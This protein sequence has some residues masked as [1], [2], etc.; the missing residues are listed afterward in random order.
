MKTYLDMVSK[1][2]KAMSRM[3]SLLKKKP[4]MGRRT[5]NYT[6]SLKWQNTDKF[7]YEDIE[8]ALANDSVTNLI[9]LY[10]W[11]DIVLTGPK[12]FRPTQ[13]QF[14]VLEHMR[15]SLPLEDY[16]QPFETVIIE[17]PNDYMQTKI[18]HLPQ[19][20]TTRG[21]EVL[22]ENHQPTMLMLRLDKPNNLLLTQTIFDSGFSIKTAYSPKPNQILEEYIS[23][24]NQKYSD[25]EECTD[26]EVRIAE[27]VVRSGINYCL[28]L[29]EVGIKK[30]GGINQNYYSNLIKY[31]EKAIKNKDQERA[32][33]LSNEIRS[34]PILYELSQEVKLY[35]T[36]S[37]HSELPQHTDRVVTPH[38]RRGF[39][40]MQPHG[41]NNSLRKRIR[42]APVFVNAH[43]F[44]GDMINAKVTYK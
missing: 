41:P 24:L 19:A 25:S 5:E 7:T 13:V 29:D 4:I 28:L 21:K 38:H 23:I 9:D 22:A 1:H 10:I 35:K 31:R 6:Y 37:S 43:L 27:E 32:N 39:Y 26:D 20:G 44:A 11:Q 34:Y 42:I 36:V 3:F 8:L 17:L 30:K 16:V 2:P 15:I 18:T 33:K 12:I 14:E 40:K